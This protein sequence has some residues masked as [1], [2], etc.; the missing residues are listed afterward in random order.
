MDE[1]QRKQLETAALE[2][3]LAIRGAYVASQEGRVSMTYWDQ[4][5]N[6]C[7]SA[8]MQTESASEWVSAM[9]RSL[10]IPGLNSWG[11]QA[12]LAL[13]QVCDV[14]GIIS[15]LASL[16]AFASPVS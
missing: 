14:L 12:L 7:R 16:A 11:S 3:V 15:L 4:I 5:Q 2:M 8:A 13:T 10:R 1:K 6:R 9:Q